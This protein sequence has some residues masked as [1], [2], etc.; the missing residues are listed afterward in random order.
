MG[1]NYYLHRNVC[2]HCKRGDPPLH[3]GKSSAGW[4]FS[5]RGYRSEW[6]AESIGRKIVCET[7]WRVFLEESVKAGCVV[8]DEYGR[9]VSLSELWSWVNTKRA[10][11]HNHTTYC[12]KHHHDYAAEKCWLDGNGNSFSEADFS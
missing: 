12:M 10:E 1:T 11:P 5:F 3:I 4:T 2:D 8:R 9:D 7:D 6:D